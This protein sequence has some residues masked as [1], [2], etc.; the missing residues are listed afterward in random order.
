ME[1]GR[2]LALKNNLEKE[3]MNS[4]KKFWKEKNIIVSVVKSK[5]SPDLQIMKI[6]LSVYPKK[7]EKK[8]FDKLNKILHL[9]QSELFKKASVRKFPKI[10]I[11][12]D[13]TF[14]EEDRVLFLIDSVSKNS[15]I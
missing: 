7:S 3:F 9:I 8:A 10:S 12:P 5:V 14:E 6:Y 2:I 11:F 4:L 1:E 13:S 15:S